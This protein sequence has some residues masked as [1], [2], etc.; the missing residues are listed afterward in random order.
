MEKSIPQEDQTNIRH[1]EDQIVNFFSSL[2]LRSNRIEL[3][4]KSKRKDRVL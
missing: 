3:C 1:K 2:L 4:S